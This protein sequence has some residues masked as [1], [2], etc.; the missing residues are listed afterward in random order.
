MCCY[1]KGDPREALDNAV[2]DVVERFGGEMG[3]SGWGF[4]ERD[5]DAEFSRLTKAQKVKL[6][7][8]IVALGCEQADFRRR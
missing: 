5:L 1:Y 6:T 2:A 4:G 3:D 7:A 8:E